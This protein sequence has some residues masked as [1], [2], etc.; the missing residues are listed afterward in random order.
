MSLP[1]LKVNKKNVIFQNFITLCTK[2]VHYNSEKKKKELE[3]VV[4]VPYH[5]L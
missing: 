4:E 3:N 1:Y 5:H 2:P